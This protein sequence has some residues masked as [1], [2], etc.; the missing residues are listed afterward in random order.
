MLFSMPFS[1]FYGSSVYQSVLKGDWRSLGSSCAL[2]TSVSPSMS[3][4]LTSSAGSSRTHPR[5]ERHRDSETPD[6][7]QRAPWQFPLDQTEQAEPARVNRKFPGT[8]RVGHGQPATKMAITSRPVT[9]LGLSQQEASAEPVAVC[10]PLP[11]L[12]TREFN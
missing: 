12:L 8:E 2:G 10:F 9:R 1:A 7:K 5:L 6:H 3:P 4:F 11:P